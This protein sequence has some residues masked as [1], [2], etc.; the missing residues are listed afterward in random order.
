MAI[1]TLGSRTTAEPD[2]RRRRRQETIEEALTHAIAIMTE[3]GVGALTVSEIARRLGVRGPS[4]YKYFPSL[5][6]VYDALFARGLATNAEAVH[7]AIEPWPRGAPRIRAA[8]QATVRWSMA[9]PALAQLL[10]WRVVPGFE[11]S[12]ETFQASIEEMDEVRAEF[13][14]AVRRDQLAPTAASDEAVRL[15]TVLLSG[16]ISQQLANE[17]GVAYEVGRFSSLTD[18]TIEMFLAHHQPTGRT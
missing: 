12:Q 18:Q 1:G 2:R 15:F 17:P 3:Q 11:P 13:A 10:H 16:L 9:N 7:A 6:A 14:E 5:H 8:A 4:L